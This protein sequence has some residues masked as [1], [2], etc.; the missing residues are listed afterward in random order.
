MDS[1]NLRLWGTKEQ[2]IQKFKLLGIVIEKRKKM[3][4]KD[5]REI[6]SNDQRE[7]EL[8]ESTKW[9][10]SQV[11]TMTGQKRNRENNVR[12]AIM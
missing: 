4:K 6:S 8:E 5:E 9:T 10:I 2:Q 11:I 3:K 12:E 7:I 1:R